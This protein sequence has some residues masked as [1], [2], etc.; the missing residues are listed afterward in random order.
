[1]DVQLLVI[2]KNPVP[3]EVKTRLA[4]R[5]G[6]EGAAE[7]ARAALLDT[8]DAALAAPVAR[9]TLVFNET[10]PVWLP[11]SV[12]FLRQRGG[13]LDERLANAFDDAYAAHPSAMLIIGSDTPQIT[14]AHI[15]TAAQRLTEPGVDAVLGPATDGGYWLLGLRVPERRLLLGV[16]MST[17]ATASHQLAQLGE[18]GKRIGC[19]LDTLCDVDTPD[20][21]LAVAASAP[22]SNFARMLGQLEL[23]R[24]EGV[25]SG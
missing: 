1:M 10:R 23:D 3:G 14:S 20:S 5:W 22:D 7:L 25:T 12:A 2:A 9:R 6:I 13:G 15:A 11:A 16:A 4:P 24:R 21:A 17:A 8:L 19:L 18:H